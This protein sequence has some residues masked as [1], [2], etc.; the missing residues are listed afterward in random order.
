MKTR[1]KITLTLVVGMG[2]LIS[3]MGTASASPH[4]TDWTGTSSLKAEVTT[5]ENTKVIRIK[6]LG[7]TSGFSHHAN[8]DKVQKKEN[9]SG[10]IKVAIKDTMAPW[11]N[12]SPVNVESAEFVPDGR[13]DG[14]LTLGSDHDM[15]DITL[16]VSDIWTTGG[17]ST[18]TAL[19]GLSMIWT[20]GG[21]ASISTSSDINDVWTSGGFTSIWTSGGVTSVW[22]SGGVTS[23]WTSGG[24]TSVWKNG[25]A[26]RLF[27]NFS[28]FIF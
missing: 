11:I 7:R 19:G 2:L 5:V 12:V 17:A 13:N 1:T 9:L 23:V 16:G 14:K 18:M 3:S 6:D 20:T 24:V 28:P 8:V 22:T 21:T 25:S 27:A 26:T 10:N 4:Y 15:N